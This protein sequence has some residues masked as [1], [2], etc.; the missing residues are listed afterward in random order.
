MEMGLSSDDAMNQISKTKEQPWSEN[1]CDTKIHPGWNAK[2][3]NKMQLLNNS[4]AKNHPRKLRD[5]SLVPT[6]YPRASCLA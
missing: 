6:S 5:R 3:C 2:I 4:T 1:D